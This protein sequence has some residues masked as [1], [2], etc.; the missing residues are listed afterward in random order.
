MKLSYLFISALV[1][2]CT[3]GCSF[4]EEK[5]TLCTLQAIRKH[6]DDI[7]L[8]GMW[9]VSLDNTDKTYKANLPG[10]LNGN[11][12]GDPLKEATYGCLSVR[13]HFIGKA[14]YQRTFNIPAYLAN[15]PLE[16]NLERVFWTSEVAI[17]GKKI[18]GKGVSLALPHVFQLGSLTEGSHT[19]S[20][21]VDNSQYVRIGEKGHAYGE[22]M[23]TIWNGILGEMIIQKVPEIRNV[24]IHA[25]YPATTL[26]VE[27]KDP[28]QQPKYIAKLI[29][30]KD[31]TEIE[32][33]EITQAKTQFNVADKNI[34]SWDEFSPNLYLFQI[35]D[36]VNSQIVY[37]QQIGFRTFSIEGN[38]F[39]LNGRA[40]FLRGN[41]DNCH[42]PLTG[43]PSMSRTEWKRIMK[44]QKDN[45]CNNI[46]FHSWCPPKVAFEVAD[47]LGIYLAPEAHMWID[48]WM[49]AS[50]F[51]KKKYIGIGQGDKA[52]DD[53]I[54]TEWN[55]IQDYFGN[56]PSFTMMCVGNELGNSN[57]NVFNQ[58]QTERKKF[59]HRHL[60][61]ASTA[62]SITASDDFFVSHAYPGCGLIRQRMEP[63][64]QWDYE[65]SY[66]KTKLPVVAHEIGQWPVYPLWSEIEKYTG[67]LRAWNLENYKAMSEKKNVN[68]FN[69]EFHVASGMQNKL[70][71]KDEIESFMRT[72]SVA[73][74]HLLGVQDYSG[75]GEAI[76]GWLNSFYENKGFLSEKEV[77]GFFAPTVILAKFPKY[78]YTTDENYKADLILHHYNNGQ[79]N[80]DYLDW[81]IVDAAQKTLSSGA[82][83]LPIYPN[84]TV[85]QVGS[86]EFPMTSLNGKTGR[87]ELVC[88]SRNQQFSEN[89]WPLW[90]LPTSNEIEKTYP[91]QNNEA[92]VVITDNANHAIE[93]LKA[94]KTV[95]LSASKLGNKNCFRRTY[96]GSVYWSTTWFPGQK[97]RTLGTWFDPEFAPF[98][99]FEANGYADWCWWKVMEGGR[100]FDLSELPIFRPHAM[101][102][103]DL[104]ENDRIGAIFSLKVDK[105]NLLVC[106]YDFDKNIPETQVLRAGLIQYASNNF[107]PQTQASIEWVQKM[108]GKVEVKLM[109][110]PKQFENAPI[111]I[112]CARKLEESDRDVNRKP[113]YDRIE[114]ADNHSVETQNVTLWKDQFG[115]FW[116]M[117][118][119]SSVQLKFPAGNTGKLYVYFQDPN[120][121]GRTGELTFEGRSFK[122]PEHQNNHHSEYELIMDV[123][124]EDSL[125]G[126]I[127]LKTK[128]DK[129]PNLQIRRIIYVPNA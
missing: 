115:E 109:P 26:D 46:R 47:E 99:P 129:G 21:T 41:L 128:V 79:F 45:G 39:Y 124:R 60:Y 122:I 57:F 65:K 64:T 25:P 24:H 7:N 44:I 55:L 106:G 71:Y 38:K 97:G 111:Y 101:V 103:P 61:S 59:D 83:K 123:D 28:L 119:N 102:V 84:G 37:Q 62:R 22:H 93:Q 2:T 82:I 94:G 75:Q 108:F 56:F 91:T 4:T 126:V 36:S 81:K 113:E 92:Q 74:I 15:Q 118:N 3:V 13:H 5:N 70:M 11:K 104:H 1:A 76:I 12:I 87:F 114:T 29:H 42:F 31:L 110:R 117:R 100:A 14:T 63:S 19:I 17:D 34:Q 10:T 107:K 86:V 112:E 85:K 121:L 53:Y 40:I 32:L 16:L 73:G 68:Q 98:T 90:I 66:A 80:W 9:T 8:A 127:E 50:S 120:K 96:W 88:T 116:I 18:Q 6:Q 33:G 54:Q 49:P 89:R 67:D 27:I 23:Q 51:D 58:W 78:V 35:L 105:G 72:P 77:A 125:D 48:G 43:A 20:I 30:K 69:N 52:L 95:L